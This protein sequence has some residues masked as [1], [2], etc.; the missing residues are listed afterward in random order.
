MNDC[1]LTFFKIYL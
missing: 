1:K